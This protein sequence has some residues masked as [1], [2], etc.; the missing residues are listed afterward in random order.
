[1]VLPNYNHADDISAS[2]RIFDLE[3]AQALNG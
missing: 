2:L 1:M 3:Q